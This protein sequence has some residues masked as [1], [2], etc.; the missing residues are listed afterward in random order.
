MRRAAALAGRW[1][2]LAVMFAVLAVAGCAAA[3]GRRGAESPDAAAGA[4]ARDLRALGPATDMA[5]AGRI[6]RA[7]IDTASRLAA[8][9]RVVPPALFHNML[10]QFGMRE[11]GLCY[12]WTEDL[13]RPLL[14]L[15]LKTFRLHW[16][17]AYRGSDLRE[18][19]SV[20]ITALGQGFPDGLVLDPWRHSGELYWG[21]V[22]E[23]E[24]P[25]EELPPDQW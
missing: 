24:Y 22:R 15:D 16:G 21:I 19:N 10:I 20:V 1:A 11:R 3:P 4:L 25:W 18:H 14:A 12:H 6:A 9:Y 23:D 13:M 7:A 17:V 8:D 5:E 2:A